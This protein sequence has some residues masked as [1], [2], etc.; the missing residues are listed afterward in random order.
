[1]KKLII[2]LIA[3][4]SFNA[5]SAQSRNASYRQQDRKQV[6]QTRDNHNYNNQSHSKD[7][8]YNNGQKYDRNRQVEYDRI[9]QQYDQRINGYRNDRSINTYQRDRRIRAA[10]IERQQSLRSFGGGAIVGGIAGF[11]LGVLVSH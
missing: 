10:E 3:A 5:A 4:I 11:L 2:I 8:A 6:T 7:Y 1:M 9:N